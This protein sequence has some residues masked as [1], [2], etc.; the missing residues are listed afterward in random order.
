VKSQTLPADSVA[1]D[2]FSAAD[3]ACDKEGKLS[4]RQKR[5]PAGSSDTF[6]SA[7]G[8]ML[9]GCCCVTSWRK[10]V[11][12]FLSAS[13]TSTLDVAQAASNIIEAVIISPFIRIPIDGAW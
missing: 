1:S 11:C 4:I 3:C 9:S 5:G 10:I 12:V 13:T 7:N 8:L 2:Q 6:F